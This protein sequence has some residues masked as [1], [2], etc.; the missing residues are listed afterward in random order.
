[1][2]FVKFLRIYFLQNTSG[3]LLLNALESSD[4]LLNNL[5]SLYMHVWENNQ[6]YIKNSFP[7]KKFEAQNSDVIQCKSIIV[8]ERI[9]Q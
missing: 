3:G 9:Y 6:I 1:M 8:I 2:N 5:D 4:L 7:V